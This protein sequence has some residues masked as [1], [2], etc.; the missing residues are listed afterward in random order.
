MRLVYAVWPSCDLTP[1]SL[2]PKAVLTVPVR[3]L[4]GVRSVVGIVSDLGSGHVAVLS[5][6]ICCDSSGC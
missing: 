4:G 3:P 5:V 1:V 2:G 6:V